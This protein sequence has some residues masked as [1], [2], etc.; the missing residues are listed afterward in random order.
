MMKKAWSLRIKEIMEVLSEIKPD[1]YD[2]VIMVVLFFM[3]RAHFPGGITAFGFA[4]LAAC[5]LSPHCKMYPGISVMYFL[6]TV[7]G[8]ISLGEWWQLFV[9]IISSV[10]FYSVMVFDK[11]AVDSPRSDGEVYK[12]SLWVKAGLVLTASQVLPLFIAAAVSSNSAAGIILMLF[13]LFISF[14]SFY[15]FKTE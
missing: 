1:K 2:T 10:T 8:V 7:I 5:L 13:Q 11:R 12:L 6:S 15:V 9:L 4:A 14:V 3:G